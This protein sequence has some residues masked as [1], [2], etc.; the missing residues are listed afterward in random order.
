MVNDYYSK[1]FSGATIVPFE[2]FNYI[3]FLFWLW[4]RYDTVAWKRCFVIGQNYLILFPYMVKLAPK[5]VSR[6]WSEFI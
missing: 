4:I 2:S 3:Y 5:T 6:D 1:I